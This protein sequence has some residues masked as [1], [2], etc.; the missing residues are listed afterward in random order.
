[1]S[2][3]INRNLYNNV[4]GFYTQ[5]SFR[6]HLYNNVTFNYM[7]KDDYSVLA[8]EYIHFL[9]DITTS[10]GAFNAYVIS[11]YFKSVAE[12]I[13][14]SP[15]GKIDVPYIPKITSDNVYANYH[16]RDCIYGSCQEI[17]KITEVIQIN[18]CNEPLESTDLK[19][20]PYAEI[21]VIDALGHK[22][23]LIFGACAVMESMAFLMEQYIAPVKKGA[24]DF[25]YHI[26]EMIV[27]EYYP[28]FAKNTLNIIA[29]C[30]CSLLSGSPGHT[31]ISMLIQFKNEGWIPQEPSAIYD[32]LLNDGFQISGSHVGSSSFEEEMESMCHLSIESLFTFFNSSMPRQRKWIE[33]TYKCGFALRINKRD[34]ML[35]IA[36]GGDIMH[37][38]IL[39]KLI[40]NYIGTPVITNQNSE[41]TIKTPNVPFES[42]FFFF[43]TI[44]EIFKLFDSGDC[45]CG[46]KDICKKFEGPVDDRCDYA[47]WT[48]DVTIQS[49]CTYSFLWNSWSFKK[50]N[51]NIKKIL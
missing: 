25:P 13:R 39:K 19:S 22:E 23:K 15:N 42:D 37:N 33:E 43:P 41:G 4:L 47:P 50:C 8:H 21:E 48:H 1:M 11:E 32:M 27:E 26:A 24:P 16:Y 9:Q 12:S 20:I 38:R 6:I 3:Y 7:S 46:L 51:P 44:Y 30:D 31:F 18:N 29:L 34:F 36:Q 14:N 28:E 49:L 10:Y 2:M 40:N 35:D 17:D 45:N 5:T